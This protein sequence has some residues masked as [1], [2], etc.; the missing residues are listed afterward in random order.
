MTGEQIK[1]LIPHETRVRNWYNGAQYTFMGINED[2]TYQLC[3][4]PNG[5][6]L[7]V[8]LSSFE[9]INPDK[10]VRALEYFHRNNRGELYGQKEAYEI[11]IEAI[12]KLRE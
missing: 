7:N 11:A 3:G 1:T 2:G 5:Y 6:S 12:N 4:L 8:M 10:Y 9:I